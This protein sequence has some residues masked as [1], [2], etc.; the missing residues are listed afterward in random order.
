VEDRLSE[1]LMNVDSIASRVS[2]LRRWVCK[3][4][5][6]RARWVTSNICQNRRVTVPQSAT[7]LDS[8]ASALR[9]SVIDLAGS[10][11][12]EYVPSAVFYELLSLLP[13]GWEPLVADLAVPA[14]EQ[15]EHAGTLRLL[16]LTGYL[17]VSWSIPSAGGPSVRVESSLNTWPP[18]VSLTADTSVTARLGASFEPNSVQL[19][20]NGQALITLPSAR[21]QRSRHDYLQALTRIVDAR[22]HTYN[23]G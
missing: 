17:T 5:G 10:P 18:A 19:V 16:A 1:G 4:N 15:I 21:N 22:S 12:S 2:C 6:K 8:R 7:D 3:V 13:H 23:A 9:D 11:F 14:D 20:A